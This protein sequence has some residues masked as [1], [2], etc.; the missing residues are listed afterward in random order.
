LT[1]VTNWQALQKNVPIR[2]GALAASSTR[3]GDIGF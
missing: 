3:V 1:L 2:D